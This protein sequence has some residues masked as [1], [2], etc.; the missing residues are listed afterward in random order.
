M[1][2]APVSAVADDNQHPFNTPAM[3]ERVWLE[4]HREGDACDVIVRMEDGVVYTS[5]FVTLP[6][7]E[8]Q[9]DLC[10]EATRHIEDTAPVRYAVLDTPHILVD[11]LT[12]D[13]IEDTIDNLIAMDVFESHFTR[14]TADKH[15]AHTDTRT[16][17]DGKLTTQEVAAVV[18][19]DVLVTRG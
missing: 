4:L 6:Y 16:I 10:L 9:M 19:S 14:V 11:Q 15:T 8:R 17:N 2:N 3:P 13:V 18:I 5:L 1:A 12:N 7:L